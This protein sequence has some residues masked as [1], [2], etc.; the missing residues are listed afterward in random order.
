M[1]V[2][3]KPELYLPWMTDNSLLLCSTISQYNFRR[4]KE[5]GLSS[6]NPVALLLLLF[7]DHH[8]VMALHNKMPDA[9]LN[10]R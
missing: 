8:C 5:R 6:G 3:C 4:V 1:P 9:F 10:T 7:P 2:P